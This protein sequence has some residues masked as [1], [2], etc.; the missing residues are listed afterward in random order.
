MLDSGDKASYPVGSGDVPICTLSASLWVLLFVSFA[1]QVNG[2]QT[3]YVY[4]VASKETYLIF[5]IRTAIHMKKKMR[6]R[7]MLSNTGVY[8][9]FVD[10]SEDAQKYPARLSAACWCENAIFIT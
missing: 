6:L 4:G 5:P 8:G 1:V 3:V 7:D 2:T 9:L 10:A